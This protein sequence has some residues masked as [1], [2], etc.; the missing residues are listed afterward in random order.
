L[1]V[2]TTLGGKA[3]RAPASRLL[4]KALESPLE[5]ALPPLA[6]DLPRS[7]EAR[8]DFVISEALCSQEHDLGSNHFSIR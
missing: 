2:T 4:L 5:E 3:G 8:C 6:D 7:V 1:T